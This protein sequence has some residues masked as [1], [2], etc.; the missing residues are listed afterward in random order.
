MYKKL[1]LLIKCYPHHNFDLTSIHNI[2]VIIYYPLTWCKIKI[3]NEII[4][5]YL[6]FGLCHVNPSYFYTYNFYSHLRR[7]VMYDT[8]FI[9]VAHCTCVFV[10]Y[11]SDY[12]AVNILISKTHTREVWHALYLIKTK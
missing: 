12:T 7:M 5:S 1:I 8:D 6:K 9:P 4:L 3:K 10:K 11:D 2:N